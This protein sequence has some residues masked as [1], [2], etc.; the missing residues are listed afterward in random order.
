MCFSGV[1]I[2]Y[3]ITLADNVFI[4]PNVIF[5]N[6]FTPRSKQYPKEFLKTIIKKGA[7]IGANS[8]IVRGITIGK[9]A[10]IGAGSVVTKNIEK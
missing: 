1:Q 7:L 10:M 6:N 9:Y 8:R 3:G 2:W 4:S 5:T